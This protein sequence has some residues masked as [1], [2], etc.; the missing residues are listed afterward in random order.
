MSSNYFF[1]I[2]FSLLLL[3][4]SAKL[5]FQSKD[6]ND[7]RPMAESSANF[8]M[9]NF[10]STDESDNDLIKNFCVVSLYLKDYFFTKKRY[11]LQIRSKE[12]TKLLSSNPQNESNMLLEQINKTLFDKFASEKEAFYL[13]SPFRLYLTNEIKFIKMFSKLV[14]QPINI[15]DGDG[16]EGSGPCLNIWEYFFLI[17]NTT[18]QSFYFTKT[19]DEITSY[20]EDQSLFEAYKT[21]LEQLIVN[22]MTNAYGDLDE[23]LKIQFIENCEKYFDESRNEINKKYEQV[24]IKN[25]EESG[26]DP[27]AMSKNMYLI[28]QIAKLYSNYYIIEG[29]ISPDFNDVKEL[30]INSFIDISKFGIS[31]GIGCLTGSFDDF[32]ADNIVSS[33]KSETINKLFEITNAKENLKLLIMNNEYEQLVKEDI[34]SLESVMLVSMG[35]YDGEISKKIYHFLKY[36][37]VHRRMN[38]ILI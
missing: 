29:S 12:R 22:F 37:S 30:G 7:L 10:Q 9:D 3:N 32:F 1:V 2:V 24:L 31:Y 5:Q 34:S 23:E 19:D 16:L 33:I 18:I 17:H 28:V 6:L 26:L 14:T 25:Y 21:K 13:Q 35:S 36:Y 11:N 4:C 27:N 38:R 20:T 15:S 8:V